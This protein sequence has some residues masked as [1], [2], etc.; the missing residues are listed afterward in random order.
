MNQTDRPETARTAAG[1]M[2]LH[3]ARVRIEGH[4]GRLAAFQRLLR[5][6]DPKGK[7][8]HALDLLQD[9]ERDLARVGSETAALPFAVPD[10]AAPSVPLVLLGQGD[11][12]REV[13][14][15]P[16]TGRLDIRA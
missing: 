6:L 9:L 1:G 15:D 13:C 2:T 16:Q 3:E 14:G 12:R 8:G 5:E 10:Q 7:A 4:I 11:Y